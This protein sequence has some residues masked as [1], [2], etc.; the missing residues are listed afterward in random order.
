MYG[1]NLHYSKQTTSWPT[2]SEKLR[3]FTGEVI[4]ELRKLGI[5]PALL[6]KIRSNVL[7]VFLNEPEFSG[8]NEHERDKEASAY[9]RAGIFLSRFKHFT[10]KRGYRTFIRTWPRFDEAQLLAFVYLGNREEP[11]NTA[12][13]PTPNSAE[14]LLCK[15]RQLAQQKRC[16]LTTHCTANPGSLPVFKAAIIP[17]QQTEP[18]EETTFALSSPLSTPPAWVAL[19][20]LV[21]DTLQLCAEHGYR[22]T[23]LSIGP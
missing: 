15:I 12:S 23:S 18:A 17:K 4:A 7:E 21:A 10:N 20:L 6:F 19:G 14:T 22:F 8:L 2:E 1:S 16:D 3:F 11:A 9:I 5:Q 13:C